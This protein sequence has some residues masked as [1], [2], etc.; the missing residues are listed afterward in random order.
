MEKAILIY[1][2][3]CGEQ[4]ITRKLDD[5]IKFCLDHGVLLQPYRIEFDNAILPEIIRENNYSY[6]IISGGD[7]TLGIIINLFF[8]NNINLP[9]GILPT[10]TC[11]D[12]AKCL[13]LPTNLIESLKI[14]IAGKTTKVDLGHIN[15]DLY[16]LNT[17]G[18]GLF[19]DVAYN[20]DKELKRTLGPFAYYLRALSEVTHKNS[21]LLRIQTESEVIEENVLFFFILNGTHAGGFSNVVKDACINDGL[22][23]IVLIKD[24]AHIE[25][26]NLFLRIFTHDSINDKYARR[27][28]ARY[29]SIESDNNV[30]L[31]VDGEKGPALPISVE[32]IHRALEVFVN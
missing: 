6:A 23:D 14:I 26:A 1:N 22:M 8:K 4:N 16:F 3:F 13:C 19:I 9:I 28:K 17:C 25:L 20:T 30:I 29:C 27:L 12:F 24:I 15:K 21:F 31:S 32:F 7:G 2:P 5:I 10:G 11:N 18:G